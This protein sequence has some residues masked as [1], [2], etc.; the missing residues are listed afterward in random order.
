MAGTDLEGVQMG[1]TM[2]LIDSSR[3]VPYSVDPQFRLSKPSIIQTTELLIFIAFWCA[4]NRTFF[5]AVDNKIITSLIQIFS[6][7]NGLV[8]N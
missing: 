7:R 8:T 5:S 6:Y 3:A 4:S 2:F 1:G